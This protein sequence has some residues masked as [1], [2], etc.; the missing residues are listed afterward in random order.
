LGWPMWGSYAIA[1]AALAALFPLARLATAG[2][3]SVAPSDTPI[4]TARDRR[5]LVMTGFYLPL[6]AGVLLMAPAGIGGT[7]A[8]VLLGLF[9]AFGT[10]DLIGASMMFASRD[11]AVHER[12]RLP[13][14]TLRIEP[15]A[16]ILYIA[17]VAFYIGMLSHG[18]PV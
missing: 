2:M 15:I 3:L 13:D 17:V 9:A 14:E 1:A 18:L 12:A 11:I 5:R 7:P 10:L 6:L 8:T 16:V 4:T